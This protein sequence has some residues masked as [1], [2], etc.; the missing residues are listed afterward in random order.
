M[1]ISS[2][3]DECLELDEVAALA[4][5]DVERVEGLHLTD[6]VRAQEALAERRHAEVDDRAL[7]C[8]SRRSDNEANLSQ[9]C[10]HRR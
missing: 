5:E 4:H 8:S 6:L 7:E 2:G 9:P 1:K 3:G 10:P